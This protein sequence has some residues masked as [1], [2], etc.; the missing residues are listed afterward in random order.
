LAAIQQTGL[1][2]QG[3]QAEL[4]PG[5]PVP[6]R[7]HCLMQQRLQDCLPRNELDS[8]TRP[9]FLHPAET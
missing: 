1:M 6:L 9:V 8:E 7:R 4:N 3:E 2:L 5:T